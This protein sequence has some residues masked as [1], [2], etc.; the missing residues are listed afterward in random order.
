MMK[1][2]FTSSGTTIQRER[3]KQKPKIVTK[4]RKIK[5]NYTKIKITK[6]MIQLVLLS[7][8]EQIL[9]SKKKKEQILEQ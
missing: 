1:V 5:Q 2:L 8:K 9:L 3:Q 7:R 6:K 4:N